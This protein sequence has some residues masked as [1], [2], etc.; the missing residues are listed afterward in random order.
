M[1]KQIYEYM[2]KRRKWTTYNKF[3]CR[4]GTLR[5]SNV[6]TV[7][8]PNAAAANHSGTAADDKSKP[9]KDK[10]HIQQRQIW[11]QRIGLIQWAH[12]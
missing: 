9:L 4:A 3:D 11:S 2:T 10:K 7:T 6:N 1:Q 5:R 8:N 12:D